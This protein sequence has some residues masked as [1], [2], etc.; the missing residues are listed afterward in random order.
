MFASRLPLCGVQ[1]GFVCVHRLLAYA[2]R[3][4]YAGSDIEGEGTDCVMVICFAFP[5]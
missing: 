2:V 4:L 1:R 5:L 3:Y